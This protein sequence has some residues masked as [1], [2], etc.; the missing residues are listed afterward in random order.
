[1]TRHRLLVAALIDGAVATEID[2]IRRA[3]G[4]NQLERIPPHVT[5]VPPTNVA[6]DLLVSAEQIVRDAARRFEPVTLRLGPPAT[7]PDNPSVLFLRVSAVPSLASLREALLCG[8]FAERDRADRAF[9]P[10]VTLDSRRER[11]VDDR[12]LGDLGGFTTSIEVASLSLLAQDD[13]S[14]RHGWTTLTSYHF[15]QAGV[16]G[17][18]GLE[19]QLSVG[20]T[21]SPSSRRTV[22]AWYL[23]GSESV[24]EEPAGR[25]AVATIS[26]EL[27]AAATWA[28]D[29]DVVVLTRHVVAP[30]WRA[31]G[32]GTT[33]LNFVERL[34]AARGRLAIVLGSAL[35][36]RAEYYLGRGYRR[37]VH[38]GR[39]G[40]G[41]LAL[42]RTL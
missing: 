32:I 41:N 22:A 36:D 33:L 21:L 11:F 1:M 3:L 6:D 19:V 20:T 40:A 14:S 29:G 34:E 18:G 23:D 31:V 5:L 39:V 17:R 15:G 13:T 7:F 26:S 30:S 37:D 25:F 35:D 16:V 27:V 10:H 28:L 38:V 24:G 2:G 12:L 4:S 42:T 8:P 9:V